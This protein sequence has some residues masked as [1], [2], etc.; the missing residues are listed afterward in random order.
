VKLTS[1]AVI[2][3]L[4]VAV[5]ATGYSLLWNWPVLLAE[6][7]TEKTI[8]IAICVLLGFVICPLTVYATVITVA[9]VFGWPLYFLWRVL[10]ADFRER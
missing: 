5:S 6:S 10:H 8:D 9:A 7:P 2:L 1:V 3:Y 4:V